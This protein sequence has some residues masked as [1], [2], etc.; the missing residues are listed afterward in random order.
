[1]VCVC[2]HAH[3]VCVCVCVYVYTH[4]HTH[5][6]ICTKRASLIAQTGKNLPTTQETWVRSPSQE[7]SM[8]KGLAIHSSTLAGRIPW[9]EEPAGLYSPWGCKK[10]DTTERLTHVQREG[11]ILWPEKSESSRQAEG[12][13]VMQSAFYRGGEQDTCENGK[14]HHPRPPAS[15]PSW[16]WCSCCSSIGRLSPITWLN[17]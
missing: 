16:G 12:G 13:R 1:M 2:I 15:H 14:A 8:E 5:I 7:D 3:S 10:S 9:I 4:T 6:Y 11:I 17:I